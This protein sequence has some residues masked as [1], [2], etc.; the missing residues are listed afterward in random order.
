FFMSFYYS[1]TDW[2][3]VTTT[4]LWTG[5]DNFKRI[6]LEDDQFRVSF[7]F[8]TRYTLVTVLLA[9]LVGFTLALLLTLP[10]KTRNIL[11]TVFFMP[12]VI[13]GLLLGF[14]WSF[15]FVRGFA[16]VGEATGIK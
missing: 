4:V 12:N 6:L 8:T 5:L 1:L 11:R 15:I 9:N 2:N 13:A 16:A 14:I 3:G 10:L 7:L